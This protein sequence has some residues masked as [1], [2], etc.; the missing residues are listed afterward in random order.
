MTRGG[1]GHGPSIGQ[2]ESVA[3]SRSRP[4]GDELM[5]A[6]TGPPHRHGFGGLAEPDMDGCVRGRPETKA[7]TIVAPLGA[8]GHA[9]QA[10]G[11]GSAGGAA[12]GS[13]GERQGRH[14]ASQGSWLSLVSNQ[15][16]R[17]VFATFDFRKAP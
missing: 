9:V 13:S 8:E 10:D 1:I 14:K 16:R 6:A 17:P 12:A 7:H 4:I 11:I 2:D 15:S 3:G 5:P